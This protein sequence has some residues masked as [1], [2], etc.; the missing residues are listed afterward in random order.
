MFITR[1]NFK[2]Y[3]PKFKPKLSDFVDAH[4][5]PLGS[6]AETEIRI[7]QLRLN[8]FQVG[9]TRLKKD[10]TADLISA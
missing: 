9:G 1:S 3:S 7:A 5:V 8:F 6:A 4:R 2:P 10:L